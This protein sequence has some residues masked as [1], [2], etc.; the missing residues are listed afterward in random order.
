ML[1]TRIKQRETLTGVEIK[2]VR[3]DGAKECLTNDLIAWYED[4]GI[5][6]EKTAQ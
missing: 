2:R 1:K 3:H 6:S 5:T 4:K